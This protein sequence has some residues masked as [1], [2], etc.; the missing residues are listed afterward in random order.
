[1]GTPPV[2]SADNLLYIS[3]AAANSSLGTNSVGSGDTNAAGACAVSVA[4]ATPSVVWV[5]PAATPC[6]TS[7]ALN[8]AAGQVYYYCAQLFAL[9]RSTGAVIWQNASY[10]VTSVLVVYGGALYFCGYLNSLG[11]SAVVAMAADGSV[12]WSAPMAVPA[13]FALTIQAPWAYA[14]DG[15]TTYQLDMKTGSV[16]WMSSAAASLSGPR[17]S[18]TIGADS[19]L[20]VI[21]YDE[22]APQGYALAALSGTN[23]SLLWNFNATLSTVL[24]NGFALDAAGVLYVL[25]G[26]VPPG[27]DDY[28]ADPSPT[29]YAIDAR[30]GEVKW[31]VVEN[32]DAQTLDSPLTSVVVGS[33]GV[34]YYSGLGFT[35][36]RSTSDGSLLWKDGPQPQIYQGA[37][38]LTGTGTLVVC[39]IA[40]GLSNLACMAYQDS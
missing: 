1:M 38:L 12:V 20:Y 14:Y 7:P 32:A 35:F 2:L 6:F 34:V 39:S 25:G 3:C 28:V 24:Y 21:T 22:H 37:L 29:V 8:D 30:T 26:S 13:P 10:E 36:A 4:S 23:G 11:A 16:Q 9:D 17:A 18:M 5:Q 31:Q 27:A 33:N 19:T 15:S 40:A